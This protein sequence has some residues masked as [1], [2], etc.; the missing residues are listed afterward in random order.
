V[1]EILVLVVVLSILRKLSLLAYWRLIAYHV[2]VV[3]G[4]FSFNF[5]LSSLEIHLGDPQQKNLLL[6]SV[7]SVFMILAFLNIALSKI[8]F[9]ISFRKVCLIG[10]IMGFINALMV[11]ITITFY[12]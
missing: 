5:L 7:L 6:F 4:S 3:A 8:I 1:V 11:I 9:A 10:M 12:R 2:V